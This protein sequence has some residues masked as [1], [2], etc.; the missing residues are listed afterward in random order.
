MDAHTFDVA[1][2]FCGGQGS[3]LSPLEIL[4]IRAGL[5]Q[6]KCD[7][8]FDKVYF[9]GRIAGIK[10]NYYIAYG[11][12]SCSDAFPKKEFYFSTSTASDFVELPELVES[13]ED[14]VKSLVDQTQPFIG[15]PSKLVA[16]EKLPKGAEDEEKENAPTPLKVTDLQRLALAVPHIDAETSVVPAGAHCVSDSFKVKESVAFRG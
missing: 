7:A 8:K 5:D 12:R 10:G 11:L 4:T 14:I 6:L 3:T 9:W 2:K 1:L 13:E 16:T 15:V